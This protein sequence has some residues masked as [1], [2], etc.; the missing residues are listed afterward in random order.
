MIKAEQV[1]NAVNN[2]KR[3][4]VAIFSAKTLSLAPGF[5]HGDN[6]V[7]ELLLLFRPK[8]TGERKREHIRHFVP[9]AIPPIQAP[10]FRVTH[11]GHCQRDFFL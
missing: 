11:K 1:E 10:D 2:E 5:R 9:A 4:F 7:T 8:P 3:Y 6:N